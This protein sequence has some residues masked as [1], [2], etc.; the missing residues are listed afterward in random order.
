MKSFIFKIVMALA[1]LLA[2]QATAQAQ[3]IPKCV[4]V[5][6]YNRPNWL[7]VKPSALARFHRNYGE[8]AVFTNMKLVKSELAYYLIAEEQGGPRIFAF[9]LEQKGKRLF[10]NRDY[11]VHTCDQGDLVLGTFLQMDGKIQ[12][13]RKG[14]HRIMKRDD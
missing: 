14:T 11:P 13:C 8:Q 2:F 4:K 5:A 12:G 7:S 6:K 3:K 1:I 9:E 10:L